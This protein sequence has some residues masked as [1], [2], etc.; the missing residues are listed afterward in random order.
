[1]CSVELSIRIIA[2]RLEGLR[3]FRLHKKDNQED[4]DHERDGKLVKR[5]TREDNFVVSTRPGKR[6]PGNR[7][8][9]GEMKF[10]LCGSKSI[11]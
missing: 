10:Q 1:M 11:F 2:E 8:G 7:K 6:L 3:Q 5:K 4:S 9:F